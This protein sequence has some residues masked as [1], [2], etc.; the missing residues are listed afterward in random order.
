MVLIESVCVWGVASPCL[1]DSAERVETNELVRMDSSSG[2][3]YM[4]FMWSRK[5]KLINR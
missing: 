5:R 3:T 4:F 2:Q 1:M